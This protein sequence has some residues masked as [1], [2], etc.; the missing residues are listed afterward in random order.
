MP[1]G[2]DTGG[3]QVE[4]AIKEFEQFGLAALVQLVVGSQ[5]Q[6]DFENSVAVRFD[7]RPVSV[8]DEIETID[9]KSVV[10]GPHPRSKATRSVFSVWGCLVS[11]RTTKLDRIHGTLGVVTP[12]KKKL[13]VFCQIV[14]GS[15]PADIVF[16][17]ESV[18]AF[19]DKVPLFKGHTLV[20]PRHHV[21]TLAD[22]DGVSP[23]FDRVQEISRAM[24]GA[25][26]AGGSF[27]A[28]N[29]RISQSVPHLHVH[30]VPRNKKDGLKGFFWPRTKY[31]DPADSAGYAARL[32]DW[33]LDRRTASP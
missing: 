7:Q 24:E 5:A 3:Q 30:V 4:S 26:G 28:M 29:N 15:L 21:E 27:V 8:A 25:L 16:Q 22:L 2:D 33:L 14:D 6:T 19:L 17:D 18:V 9:S 12:A 11:R 20:V 10:V 32:S 23:L 13:C 31:D 1:R